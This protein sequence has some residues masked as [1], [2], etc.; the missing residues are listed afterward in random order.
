MSFRRA[1]IVMSL[2]LSACTAR[3]EPDAK[4]SIGKPAVSANE[5]VIGFAG[6]ISGTLRPFG[7]Q[8]MRGAQQAVD[9]LNAKGGVLGRPVRLAPADDECDPDRAFLVAKKFVEQKAVLVV[10]HFCSGASLRAGQ[11]YKENAI[12]QI[13]ASATNPVLTDQ[14]IKTFFRTIGKDDKAGAFAGAWFAKSYSG[15]N[16]AVLNDSSPYGLGVAGEARRAMEAG[17]LLPVLSDAYVRDQEDFSG[18]IAKLKS[19][20]V[21]A[22]YVGGFHEDLGRLVKQARAQGYSGAFAGGDAL[23]TSELW[24][25]AGPAA[26]GLRFT[27]AAPSHNLPTARELAQEL[28]ASDERPQIYAF[29]AYAAVQAWA[30]AATIA[31]TTDGTKVAEVLH[32]TTIPT[33]LGDLSWDEA[34]DLNNPRYAWFI[35]HNGD[36]AQ[37]SN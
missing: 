13:T 32:N 8:A 29:T 2:L 20:K 22:A 28:R 7:W 36:F 30:A 34:G 14:E 26:D 31:N 27:D 11:T 24:T 19:A 35:W 21:E 16:V 1:L 10:G 33:V 3:D 37:E 5:T 23:N 18:L 25:I 4:A 17:G 6:P 9:D 15:R 12:V